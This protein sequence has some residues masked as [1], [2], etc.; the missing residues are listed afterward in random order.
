MSPILVVDV[1]Q[2][3]GQA[4]F[5]SMWRL[6]PNNL[7]SGIAGGKREGADSTGSLGKFLDPWLRPWL[8]QVV[9]A[10]QGIP[11]SIGAVSSAVGW[12]CSC[13]CTEHLHCS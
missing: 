9:D 6:F 7:S 13:M 4:W 3:V 11:G 10:R 2:A 12:M 5:E 8:Q 1:Y